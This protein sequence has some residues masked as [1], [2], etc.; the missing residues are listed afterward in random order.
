MNWMM[1]IKKVEYMCSTIWQKINENFPLKPFKIANTDMEWMTPEVKQLIKQ[2]QK[3][4]F[5]GNIDLSN[6]LSKK[7]PNRN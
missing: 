5:T 7:S 6:H 2:R 3:A 4:H 1:L